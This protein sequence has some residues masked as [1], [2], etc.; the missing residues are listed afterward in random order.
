MKKI[1]LT[2]LVL[3]LI[4][5]N[6]ENKKSTEELNVLFIGNSLTF[7]HE[8]PLMVQK[9]LNETN[10][11]IKIHQSTFPGM[12]LDWHLNK[13]IL[14]QNEES[15]NVRNKKEGEITETE[16]K[17]SE[18]KWDIIIL[19]EGTIR[20]II[21]E[22]RNLVVDSSIKKFKKIVNNPNCKFI[23]FNTWASKAEY[24][25]E[26]CYP[27]RLIDKSL[28]SSKKYCSESI[29]NLE[30]HNDVINQAYQKL[31]DNNNILKSNN[32]N[33]FYEIRIKHPEIEL[34]D[35]SF[36]PSVYGSFLN[37]CEFYQILSNEKAIDLKYNGEIEPEVANLLK[38][39]AE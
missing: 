6:A 28:E 15:I 7:Y 16:R 1:L 4:S 32:G 33:L 29:E 11:N 9:M 8:M 34:F 3:I 5:C 12:F 27:G 13:T 31:A 22:S 37:A 25:L 39:I 30:Q 21:P 26:K 10:P 2:I 35:D 19:Q 24:P 23:L 17:L 18:R 14:T 20:V 36:H 38:K